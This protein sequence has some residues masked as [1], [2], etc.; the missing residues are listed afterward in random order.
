M[1]PEKIEGGPVNDPGHLNSIQ[2]ALLEGEIIE[3]IRQ[4]YDPELP[5]NV[6]DLGLIY[7]LNVSHEGVVDITM[8][9][10]SPACPVAGTLPGEVEQA[11]LSTPGV[12]SA[13]VELVWDPPYTIDRMPEHI[14]LELG[15]F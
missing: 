15:L 7:G 13:S 12:K 11:A 14:R 3:S 10:T 8:T 9:L 4:V 1:M 2:R 6:Y 5:I